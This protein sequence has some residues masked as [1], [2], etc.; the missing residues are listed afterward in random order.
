MLWITAAIIIAVIAAIFCCIFYWDWFHGFEPPRKAAGRLGED[1]AAS[2][3]QTILH[4]DDILL[5]NVFLSVR[6]RDTELDNVIVNRYGVFIIEVKNY[7]GTLVGSEE[8]FTWKKSHISRAGNI[9]VKEVKNPVRQV[10]RQI[11]I[12]SNYLGYYGVRVWVKGYAYLLEGNSPVASRYILS[13]AAEI[14]R[15]IHTPGRTRLDAQTLH[16]I[17]ALLED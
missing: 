10:R 5:N 9:Y 7:S 8:D 4:D 17:S 3:I 16:F 2:I 14:D 11:Y 6:G 13:N 1:V 12:L 15:A